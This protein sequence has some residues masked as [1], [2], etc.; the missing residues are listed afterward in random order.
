MVFPVFHGRWGEGG[1]A[2]RLLDERGLPYVGCRE[3]GGEVV[4]R[5]GGD[6]GSVL[7]GAGLPTPDWALVETEGGSGRVP[8]VDEPLAGGGGGA[9]T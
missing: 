1:E 2:Q 4:L 5:Q 7:R 9:Q 6:E 3:A 8:A